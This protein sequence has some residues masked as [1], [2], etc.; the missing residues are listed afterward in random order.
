MDSKHPGIMITPKDQSH[1]HHGNLREAL[2]QTALQILSIDGV[3]GL[4]LRKVAKAAGVSHAAPAHH[5]KDK[6]ALV[7]SVAAEG[8]RILSKELVAVA[9]INQDFK[10][11]LIQLVR[12]YVGFAQREVEL[13]RLIFG[14]TAPDYRE[15][16]ELYEAG[17]ECWNTVVQLITTVMKDQKITN[18]E[19][20][21]LA[22]SIWAHTQGIASLIVNQAVI[23]PHL[24]PI[25]GAMLDKSIELLIDGLIA[26]SQ[27]SQKTP[28]GK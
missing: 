10:E 24:I 12:T 17:I 23:P 14:P 16:P 3:A 9:N 13:F 19:P 7:A 22:F 21:L 1:Y 15:Y 27:K 5:F 26:A 2:I 18:C 11:Q 4:T 6:T 20:D 8:F 25:K 28:A